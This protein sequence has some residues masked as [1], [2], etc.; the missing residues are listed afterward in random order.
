MG[1]YILEIQTIQSN[2]IKVLCDVLKETLNDVNFVFDE[3]GMRVMAMDGSHV[4]LIHL[5]LHADKFEVFRCD[6][7]INVGLNMANLYKLIKTVTN[8]DAVTFFIDQD[9]PNEFGI[10]IE[11]ADR[12]SHTTFY[13]KMLDIDESEIRLPDIQ[14]DSVITMPSNDFQRICR[15]MFNISDQIQISTCKQML[16]LSCNGE[17]AS[18]ETLIGEASHGLVFSRHNDED[19]VTGKFS[20]KYINLFTKSTNLSNSLQIYLK[21]DYPFMLK[22]NV[23]N[24]GDIMFCLAPSVA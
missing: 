7:K 18:Q 4:A 10:R 14:L 5:K 16:K 24:L 9:N 17:F 20:L 11:N 8:M 13:L 6:Q 2:V 3:G 23:A 22:Y 12:N 19:E 1:K 21:K 15:D